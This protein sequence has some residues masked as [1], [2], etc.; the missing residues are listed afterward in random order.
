MKNAILPGTSVHILKSKHI[1]D[2]IIITIKAPDPE[3]AGDGPF[4]VVYGTDADEG[5]GTYVETIDALLMG[6]EIPPLI[7][8]GVGYSGEG[9]FLKWGMNR[10]RDFSPT[11][12]KRHLDLMTEAFGGLLHKLEEQ[13]SFYFS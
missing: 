11:E 6:G 5:L 4:P 1:E 7:F 9:D 10:T 3:V 2:D 12:D 13:K 8:V